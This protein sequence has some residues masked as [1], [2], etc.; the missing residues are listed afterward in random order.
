[1]IKTENKNSII[2]DISSNQIMS[3]D[4]YRNQFFTDDYTI[5]NQLSTMNQYTNK[6]KDG[7]IDRIFLSVT[8]FFFWI[9]LL[10]K[11]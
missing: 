7:D 3:E 8:I 10:K 5:S 1:M 2:K 4:N 9:F 6:M 11:L